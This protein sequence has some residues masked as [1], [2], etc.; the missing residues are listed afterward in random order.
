MIQAFYGKLGKERADPWGSRYSRRHQDPRDSIEH[1]G[2]RDP[3]DL[4]GP[5]D[6]CLISEAQHQFWKA[7]QGQGERGQKILFTMLKHSKRIPAS[8][9]VVCK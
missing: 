3:R 4:Q 2:P 5:R 7:H 8:L 9:H 6:G 1:Q